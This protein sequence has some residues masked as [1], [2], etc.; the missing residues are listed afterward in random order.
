MK[1]QVLMD[2]LSEFLMV[3]E[4]GLHLYR[5]VTTRAT[6]PALRQRYQE[7][8]RETAHHRE[9]LARLIE[10]VGGDPN[11]ISPTARLAQWKASKLLESSLAVAGLSQEEIEA[12]DLENVL[13][14]ET[15]DHAD[16]SLLQQMAQGD[17]AQDG[18]TGVIARA[19]GAVTGNTGENAEMDPGMIQQ[20]LQ[21]AVDE[22]EQEEDEHLN[23]ARE[24]LAQMCLRM[25]MQGPAPSPERWQQ[26]VIAPEPPITSIH[27]RP[28]D[29]AGLLPPAAQPA[30]QEPPVMRELRTG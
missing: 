30:W 27:P 17:P 2:K 1:T 15:K 9:V 4:C 19:V 11:Y 21:E 8:G 7:F 28:M 25:A 18:V 29:E 16:W 24:T 13:L 12:N 26:N 10:R 6:D 3:E 5:V 14:A 20:A 23:W 22:V